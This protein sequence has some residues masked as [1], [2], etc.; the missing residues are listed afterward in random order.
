MKFK[1]W[2]EN[3]LD[4][5]DSKRGFRG[6]QS[7]ANP[8][9]RFGSTMT[10]LPLSKDLDNAAIA[11]LAGGIG[12]AFRR[13]LR[14]M[15]HDLSPTDRIETPPWKMEKPHMEGASLPLQ[16]PIINNNEYVGEGFTYGK[17]GI[18]KLATIVGE[19]AYRDYK[20]R[21]ANDP[22]NAPNKFE[23]YTQGK[24]GPMRSH[25]MATAFTQALLHLAVRD[26][27]RDEHKGKYDLDSMRLESSHEDENNIITCVFS[28]KSNSLYRN[29]EDEGY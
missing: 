16:L 17:A 15:G 26:K 20:I 4:E 23:K 5:V 27:V 2:L 25:Q 1:E 28:I 24:E 29:Q 22:D 10:Q 21:T 7:A 12:D 19:P 6:D 13:N 11:G 14:R 9:S 18:R 8:A 3:R